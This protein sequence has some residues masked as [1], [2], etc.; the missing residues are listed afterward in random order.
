ELVEQRLLHH[1]PLAHHRC[2]LLLP[3]RIE[4]G[5]QAAGN[6][7]FFNTIDPLRTLLRIEREAPFARLAAIQLTTDS[8]KVRIVNQRATELRVIPVG[9]QA[10]AAR[11]PVQ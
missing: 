7:D 3:R 4:S 10:R 11:T 2:V 5:L 9:A 1:R 6:T 8:P